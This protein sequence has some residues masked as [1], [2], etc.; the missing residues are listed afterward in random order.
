[1]T[2]SPSVRLAVIEDLDALGYVY[3]LASLS[4][5]HDR[6]NLLAH[7]ELLDL[8]PAGVREGRTLAA[9]DRGAVVGFATF[10]LHAEHLELEALFVEP[11]HQRR[12]HAKRLVD[13]V[14]ETAR[15]AGV[16][17]VEVTANDHASGFYDAAG[18]VAVGTVETRFGP[19]P[20]KHLPV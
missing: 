5:D 16:T 1:M 12:G 4:N 6:P 20:R 14:V 17:R 10:S 7:P 11:D 18:F 19:A 13:A 15:R 2:D 3:R 9:V 8:D